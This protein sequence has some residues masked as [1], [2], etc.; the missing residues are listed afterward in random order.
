MG[1]SNFLSS[2]ETKLGYLKGE[3]AQKREELGR[4][5]RLTAAAPAIEER[6]EQLVSLTDAA[7]LLILNYHPDWDAATIG[8]V[9]SHKHKSPIRVGEATRKALDVLREAVAPMRTRDIAEEVLRREGI[10]AP[11][12]ATVDRVTNSL[13]NTLKTRIGKQVE[14]DRQRGQRWSVIRP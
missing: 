13:G 2:L 4:I 1:K 12:S 10:I 8:P 11:D 9:R 3:L 6:I 7:A 14:S 5:Q